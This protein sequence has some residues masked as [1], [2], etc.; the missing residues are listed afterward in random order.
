MVRY[1]PLNNSFFRLTQTRLAKLAILGYLTSKIH[2]RII[3]LT[4][5]FSREMPVFPGDMPPRWKQVAQIEEQGYNVV[6][7]HSGMHVGTHIDAPLHMVDGGR[8]MAEISAEQFIGP[9]YVVDARGQN[10]V[11]SDSLDRPIP[12]GAIVLV[13]TGWD[14][15]FGQEAYYRDYP[16]LSL[17]FADRL[18]EAG[19]KIVGLDFPSP[20]RAPYLVHQRLLSNGVLIMENLIGIEALLPYSDFEVFALPARYEADGAPVRVLARIP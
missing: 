17:G 6:Q 13:H 9:G 16:E 20:D 10:P 3:D 5:V 15:L 12:A 11:I 2:M 18:V 4:R 19:V 8:H 14:R 7:L 1:K